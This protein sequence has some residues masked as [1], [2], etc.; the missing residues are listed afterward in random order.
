MNL[1]LK[2]FD[3]N[4][5]ERII[6]QKEFQSFIGEEWKDV[7]LKCPYVKDYRLEISNLGR[8][9]SVT[10]KGL[11]LLKGSDTNGYRTIRLKMFKPRPDEDQIILDDY[12]KQIRAFKKEVK[13]LEK[14]GPVS[15]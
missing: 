15:E 14:E 9:R 8:V 11:N 4:K 1:I 5:I 10:P 6:M 7:D 13:R 3:F 2:Q 12:L